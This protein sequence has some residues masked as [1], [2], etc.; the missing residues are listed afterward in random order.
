MSIVIQIFIF[1]T[2][3]IVDRITGESVLFCGMRAIGGNGKS[4]V[5][6]DL[7]FH[8]LGHRYSYSGEVIYYPE[9]ILQ[10]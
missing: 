7:A 6:K 2:S 10:G 8:D 4:V 1:L 9:C 5:G 3:S